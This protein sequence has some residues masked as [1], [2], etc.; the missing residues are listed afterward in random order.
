MMNGNTFAWRGFSGTE[1][2]PLHQRLGLPNQDSCHLELE[3]DLVLVAVSDGLGSKSLSHI[4]S[5]AVCRAVVRV[6][7]HYECIGN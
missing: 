5:Q 7:R 2:G 3:N 4:G 1:V 6:A